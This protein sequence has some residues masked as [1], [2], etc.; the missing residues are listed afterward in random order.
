MQQDNDQQQRFRAQ[1]ELSTQQRAAIL[2]LR[3]LDTRGAS[4]SAALVTD[5]LEVEEMYRLKTIPLRRGGEEAP[6]VFGITTATPQSAVETLRSRYTALGLTADFVLMSGSGY[7]EYMQ[8]FDPPKTV[9]YEDVKIAQEGDSDTIAEVSQTLENVRTDDILSYL[10]NQ[11]DRLRA[12]DIHI[13][14][15]RDNVR[16]RLRVDGTLHP[17]ATITHDK[18][19]ILLASIASRADISTAAKEPQTGHMQQESA[20]K[21]GQQINM[22]I[23]TIASTFG[24]DAVIRLF[25]FDQSLLEIDRLGI[26]EHRKAALRDLIAH[27]HG[28]LLVVGPTG[29]GKSTTLYTMLN[30][31]NDP[32]RKLLTLEDPVEVNIVGTTQVPV[33]TSSGES[34]ADKL[35]AVMRLDPDVIMVGE[36]RD[37]DTART[38]IQASITGH[39]VLSTFHA[40]S[41]AAAFSRMIDMIGQN[42]I[43]TNAIRMVLS[44]RLVRRLDDTT[45]T[46]YEPDET[47]KQW[48]REVLADLPDWVERPNL[49]TFQ[50]WQPGKSEAAP[51]GY[52]GR[53]M[54]AELLIVDEA[55]QGFIRGDSKDIDIKAIENAAR[56]AGMLTML[57]DGVLKALRGETTLEEIYKAL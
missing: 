56:S 20:T 16:I 23:E 26:D 54:V 12:S 10:I 40:S 6:Y 57:Q 50:L 47:T 30:A 45:K 46:S 52:S 32:G 39:L 5:V 43:F 53:V 24:Q 36:I 31:L 28:M 41:S 18:Y 38:A 19:R 29:S 14:S 4:A 9:V 2:G 13:E 25:N 21:P 27:P 33:D 15:Q 51:F 3:Y 35:R 55:V 8:R 44:Q 22:R 1:D 49:D 34:F 17:I 11:A 48:V 37:T 7:R 42:P